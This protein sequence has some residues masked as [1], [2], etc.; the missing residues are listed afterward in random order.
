MIKNILLAILLIGAVVGIVSAVRANKEIDRIRVES[1]SIAAVRDSSYLA[2][3]KESDRRQDSLDALRK[4]SE[5]DLRKAD[6][7]QESANWMKRGLK[8]AVDQARTAR[9]SADALVLALAL[10]D[11]L[12]VEIQSLRAVHQS[13]SLR[14]LVLKID[15]DEWKSEAD[16]LRMAM[17]KLNSNVGKIATVSKRKVNLGILSIPTE[18]ATGILG[19]GAGYA[20]AKIN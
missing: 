15:R 11:T 5:E 8:A 1:D 19:L 17:L 4:K 14:L 10:K 20:V 6:K 18:V 13:D 16:S 7:A 3:Q 9:D 2:L 12:E